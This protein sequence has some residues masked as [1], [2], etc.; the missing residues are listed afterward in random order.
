MYSQGLYAITNQLR[1]AVFGGGLRV[2][3]SDNEEEN[4]LVV[5]GMRQVMSATGMMKDNGTETR[6]YDRF[7]GK[8]L[9]MDFLLSLPSQAVGGIVPNNEFAYRQSISRFKKGEV[10]RGVLKLG[11]EV[12]D[13]LM[14]PTA[15]LLEAVND[16]LEQEKLD[17]L[18]KRTPVVGPAIRTGY[19]YGED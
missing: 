16:S 18:L 3:F 8:G 1:Q 5:P 17:P 11:E 9:L 13:N 12:A 2:G 19:R 6:E 4:A 7:D 14:V 15:I 10:G